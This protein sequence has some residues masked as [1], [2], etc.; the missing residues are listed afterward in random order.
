V[1]NGDGGEHQN[2]ERVLSHVVP[3]EAPVRMLDQE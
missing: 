2:R 1:G 3:L